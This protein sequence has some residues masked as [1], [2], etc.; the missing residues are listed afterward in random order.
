M[1]AKTP[2]P[3]IKLP[4]K[5]TVY[6]SITVREYPTMDDAIAADNTHKRDHID[7]FV[8]SKIMSFVRDHLYMGETGTYTGREVARILKKYQHNVVRLHDVIP[9][10]E[11]IARDDYAKAHP[12][13]TATI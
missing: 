9:E 2:A 7:S 11:Q 1:K 6:L 12:E 4:P 5:K 13:S 3:Q 8:E 10:W